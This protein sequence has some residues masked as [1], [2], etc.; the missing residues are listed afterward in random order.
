MSWKKA[1]SRA[2]RTKKKRKSTEPRRARAA[3]AY[4]ALGSNRGDR[5][6]HLERALEEL[7][8]RAPVLGVS[9]LYRTEPVGYPDQRLF[10]NAVVAIRWRGSAAALLRATQ[11]IEKAVGRTPSF[12]NGPREID[13]D[14]LDLDGRRRRTRDPLLPHPRMALRRFV[15]APLAELAPRWRHPESGLTA[16]ELLRTLSARPRATR[17][18]SRPRGSIARRPGS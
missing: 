14:I 11:S 17:I 15:L 3:I 16:G 7:S 5:R 6:A 13:I 18:S 2:R 12:R 9:S 1:K 8:R 4:L 10:W